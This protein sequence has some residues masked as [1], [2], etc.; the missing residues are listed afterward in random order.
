MDCSVFRISPSSILSP[1]FDSS[2]SMDLYLRLNTSISVVSLLY[3]S[4][5]D[6]WS[7]SYLQSVGM[8]LI[9]QILTRFYLKGNIGK[10][11]IEN[12]HCPLYHV[13]I[14]NTWESTDHNDLVNSGYQEQIKYDQLLMQGS[15]CMVRTS[16]SFNQHLIWYIHKDFV[17]ALL[18]FHGNSIL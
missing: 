13:D 9:Q 3:Y 1:V 7:Y 2:S 11:N 18:L 15:D 5:T 14:L 4:L 16:I 6:D 17:H 12:L 10:A 8:D